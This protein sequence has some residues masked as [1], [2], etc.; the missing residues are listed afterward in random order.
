MMM[1]QLKNLSQ[2]GLDMNDIV[3]QVVVEYTDGSTTSSWIGDV[4]GETG[5]SLEVGFRGFASESVPKSEVRYLDGNCSGKLKRARM[6]VEKSHVDY[7]ELLRTSKRH[8][9][10]ICSNQLCFPMV[11]KERQLMRPP[12]F[13]RA[14]SVLLSQCDN[15]VTRNTLNTALCIMSRKGLN[16]GLNEIY[17]R[18]CFQQGKIPHGFE[19]ATTPSIF[20]TAI[21]DTF[22]VTCDTYAVHAVREPYSYNRMRCIRCFSSGPLRP[23]PL[24]YGVFLCCKPLGTQREVKSACCLCKSFNHSAITCVTC[25]CHFCDACFDFLGEYCHVGSYECMECRGTL[26]GEVR[27]WLNYVNAFDKCVFPLRMDPARVSMSSLRVV[28]G[29]CSGVGPS[30]SILEKIG[31][32]VDVYVQIEKDPIASAIAEATCA[33]MGV[34]FDRYDDL[35]GLNFM[36]LQDI[37]TKYGLVYGIVATPPCGTYSGQNITRRNESRESAMFT[38]DGSLL[39]ESVALINAATCLNPNMWFI[40]EETA[41]LPKVTK[42]AITN[43]L[44]CAPPM[45]INSREICPANIPRKRCYWTNIPQHEK[46]WK[47]VSENWSAIFGPGE[48]PV[49]A[50]DGSP[51]QRRCIT[52]SCNENAR[53]IVKRCGGNMKKWRKEWQDDTNL[54]VRR[55]SVTYSNVTRKIREFTKEELEMIMGVDWGDLVTISTKNDPSTLSITRA[56][57]NQLI[58]LGLHWPTIKRILL[59]LKP[60]LITQRSSFAL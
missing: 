30:V 27:K 56:K 17:R 8:T 39:F 36:C 32:H 34:R 24:G 31:L 45:I 23:H 12:A 25:G 6:K 18:L 37:V 48:E 47:P 21:M 55:A 2:V 13:L 19:G 5:V 59:P 1:I 35:H 9:L 29:I 60:N 41:G 38:M 54:V 52:S 14:V 22:G 44:R 53:R 40:V 43:Q 20:L 10:A 28:V 50:F 3:Q 33:R 51:P 49:V 7:V 16:I 58:G 26:N 15:D 11:P 46:Y 42:T 57:H 4:K